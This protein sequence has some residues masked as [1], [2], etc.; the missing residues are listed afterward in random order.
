MGVVQ[1]LK[2]GAK[3]LNL[4]LW[5]SS[6]LIKNGITHSYFCEWSAMKLL[7]LAAL[8]LFSHPLLIAASVID[9]ESCLNGD[10]LDNK[11]AAADDECTLFIAP[12]RIP[13]GG[14]GVFT[15]VDLP[16]GSNIGEPDMCIPLIDKFKT[17]PYRGQHRWL[18]WLD[19]VRGTTNFLIPKN[20][21]LAK[22]DPAKLKRSATGPQFLDDMYRV[23]AFAPGLASMAISHRTLF[24]IK[25]KGQPKRDSMGLQRHKDPGTGAFASHHGANFVA[26]KDIE[27]GSELHIAATKEEIE[28][29]GNA[30]KPEV[31]V[32]PN[33]LK[34]NGVCIDNLRVGESTISQ[35]GR[36]AF[37]KRFLAEGSLI[38]PTSLAV[39][40]RDDLIIYEANEA[41]SDYE[42]V[43]NKE[44][45]VGTE[46]II[47]YCF[48]HPDS[49]LL[50]LPLSPVVNFINH[51]GTAPNAEIRW[52]R[53]STLTDE[54]LNLHPLE[55]IDISGKPMLEF[56]ALRDIMKDEEIVI[57]Y[58]KDW[59]EAWRSHV[60]AWS[61]KPEHE[62]YVSAADYLKSGAFNIRTT[63]EQKEDP[64]PDN[65][66]TVC[67]FPT[68]K[69]LNCWLPC[70]I[71]YAEEEN[72]E[73]YYE[74]SYL[75]D[76]HGAHAK[77]MVAWDICNIKKTEGAWLLA[78]SITVIDKWGSTDQHLDFAFRHAMG[79]SDDLFPSVW[80]Q[81]AV[82]EIT[83][84]ETPLKAGQFVAITWAHNGK[85]VTRN[86][87]FVGLPPNFNAHLS[88]FA[89]RIGV[90][91]VF[92]DVLNGRPNTIGSHRYVDMTEGRYYVQRPHWN[93]N[94][95]WVIP[96]DE[97][98]RKSYLRTLGSGGFGDVLDAMG[99]SFGLNQLTCFHNTFLGLSKS[100][101]SVI[102]ADFYE[103][104]RRSFDF[105]LPIIMANS[106]KPELHLQSQDGNVVVGL[107][108]RYGVATTVGDWT[109]H[110]SAPVDYTDTGEIRVV[111]SIYCSEIT[112]E[113]RKSLLHMYNQE[114]PAPFHH[115]FDLPIKEWHWDHAGKKLPK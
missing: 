98:A 45:V 111:S 114:H 94:M 33:W 62:T 31:T 52:P 99:T 85:P 106:T 54:W 109:Y 101:D 20:K 32:S 60:K 51:N 47:N 115:L 24:N 48:E 29:K 12:S 42:K 61:P 82:Y 83:P 53:D 67:L 74:V 23:D 110:K 79:V 69:K 113:N 58:G 49:P 63:E 22:V 37:A 84:I 27:A 68:K 21:P 5:R 81:P 17:I 65:L 16:Q 78:E 56:V 66:L 50:F 26:E 75:A 90:M 40:K 72:G 76:V 3:F 28:K 34:K 38:A 4:P 71:G 96:A 8:H 1:I 2:F 14:F 25:L 91:D 57:D 102:H 70:D 59:E 35:A 18:S 55:M 89:E 88:D 112:A 87:N 44:N 93:S 103:T 86:A 107:K 100:D 39:L 46:L 92:R 10:C 43:L 64:Y 41:A 80:M 11:E 108:Y 9:D 13:N 36:G 7:L 77:R 6:A 97:V 30:S 19:Y 15:T 105:L 104:Q 73:N 95:H